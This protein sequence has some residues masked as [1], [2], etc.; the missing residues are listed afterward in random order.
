MAGNLRDL[1]Y[2]TDISIDDKSLIMFLKYKQKNLNKTRYDYEVYQSYDPFDKDSEY[3]KALKSSKALNK[4]SILIKPKF[5]TPTT[6]ENLEAELQKFM[7]IPELPLPNSS[8]T[9][10][11]KN[12]L[13][14]Y[15]EQPEALQTKN[16]FDSH[17][18]NFL[19]GKCN[20]TVI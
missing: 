16:V 9:V 14:Q 19:G 13:I 17:K 1:G 12:I 5:G 3:N 10:T 4:T 8:L 7:Q 20:C 2:V 6:K 15:D 18:E 11:N